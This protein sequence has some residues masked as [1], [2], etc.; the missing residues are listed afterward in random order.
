M[1]RF[2]I[3]CITK[4]IIL[5]LIVRGQSTTEKKAYQWLCN[6]N[7]I[8]NVSVIII[9][10][11]LNINAIF[12]STPQVSTNSLPMVNFRKIELRSNENDKNLWDIIVSKPANLAKEK[13]QTKVKIILLFKKCLN[14][15][16]LIQIN[17][18]LVLLINAFCRL[19]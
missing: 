11:T 5:P 6:L 13:K 8:Q 12:F 2:H 19:L 3:S 16:S 1:Y 4:I 15:V 17:Y 7:I 14:L 18:F 9:L 10:L